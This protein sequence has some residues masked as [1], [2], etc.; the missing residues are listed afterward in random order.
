MTVFGASWPSGVRKN[1]RDL[2]VP[3]VMG[4]KGEM[5]GDDGHKDSV[6]QEVGEDRRVTWEGRDMRKL[7]RNAGMCSALSDGEEAG[8]APSGGGRFQGLPLV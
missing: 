5:T 6:C 8:T 1:L 7:E 4:A 2:R 3:A